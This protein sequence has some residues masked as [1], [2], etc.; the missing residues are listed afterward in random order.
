MSENNMAKNT[1][2]SRQ[3]PTVK[4][5]CALLEKK[6]RRRERAF[7][8]DGIKLLCEAATKDVCIE[9]VAVSETLSDSVRLKIEELIERGFL[10]SKKIFC[11]SEQVFEKMSE[12]C[13]PEG[14]ITVARFLENTHREIISA[15][16]Y[17][18]DASER[19][20]LAE[21]LRDPGN[22]G[23]VIRTSAALGIDRLIITDDC[24]DLYSPKTVRAAMGGLFSLN[25]DV[26]RASDMAELI[27][28]LRAR[29]RRIYATALTDNAQKIGELSLA[30]GDAFVIG[31]EGH[32]LSK[33][34]IDASSGVA[35]IPMT[36]GSESLNA[37]A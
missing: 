13:S 26:V 35:I 29:G 20:L 25:I 12:E 37:A 3:N 8:F 15:K 31:N 28:A 1:V 24:A 18:V 33:N 17:S 34:V 6:S 14:V 23:T 4:R 21:S 7:R 22:L 27:C 5:I 30:C 9:L 11:V 16:E 32:G 36:E 19:I 10:D 2:T